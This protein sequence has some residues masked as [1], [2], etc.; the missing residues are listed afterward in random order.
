MQIQEKRSLV[1]LLVSIIV[2]GTY[3]L[4]FY[5]SYETWGLDASDIFYFYS[6]FFVGMVVVNV[7][8]QIIGMIIFS[9]IQSAVNEVRGNDQEELDF[10]EDE[11]DKLIQ[12]KSNQISMYVF[13]AGV[14]IAFISQLFHMNSHL[15]FII[16][17]SFGF[18]S[19]LASHLKSICY[20]R[21]GV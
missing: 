13:I 18:I 10:K 16:L 3:S 6:I 2:F 5:L 11:R 9:I 14:G 4:V 8:S 12:M 1:N 19:D 17:F 7:L 21:R 15:F 20:Y